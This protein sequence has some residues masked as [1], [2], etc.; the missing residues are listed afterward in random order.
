M[1]YQAGELLSLLVYVN[2]RIVP[3]EYFVVFLATLAIVWTLVCETLATRVRI[4]FNSELR[5]VTCVLYVAAS[6]EARHDR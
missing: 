6:R 2:A 1:H 3:I 5:R 4:Y